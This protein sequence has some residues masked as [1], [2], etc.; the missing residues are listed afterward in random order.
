MPPPPA[1]CRCSRF[2]ANDG[3]RA[4]DQRHRSDVGTAQRHPDGLATMPR[5][6]LITALCGQDA[7]AQA[8]AHGPR[9]AGDVLP[10]PDR[11]AHPD[12]GICRVCG[13]CPMLDDGGLPEHV[14]DP[15]RAFEHQPIPEELR[16]RGE[17]HPPL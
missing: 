5:P 12:W 17:G 2:L 14:S 16:C 11:P 9:M 8:G 3:F 10:L 6:V 4:W 1:A 7:G 15:E 13:Q